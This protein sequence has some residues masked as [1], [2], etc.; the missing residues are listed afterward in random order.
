MQSVPKILTVSNFFVNFMIYLYLNLKFF[1]MFNISFVFITLLDFG[2][3]QADTN[4]L[5]K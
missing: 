3:V 5:V 4:F 1:E 2:N